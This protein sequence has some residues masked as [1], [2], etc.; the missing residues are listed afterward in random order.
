[1]AAVGR[2]GAGHWTATD[3]IRLRIL[4]TASGGT[5]A[6]GF[7]PF[8]L[9]DL[10]DPSLAWRLCSVVV[11]ATIVVITLLRLRQA[12]TVGLVA[13]ARGPAVLRVMPFVMA[14]VLVANAIW[15]ATPALYVLGLLWG[16]LVAFVAFVALLLDAWQQPEDTPQPSG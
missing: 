11:A 5:V 1:V 8:V 4:L 13:E 15:L 3:Q 2:R 7:L 16:V 9:V 12:A 6:Y 14:G 10:I